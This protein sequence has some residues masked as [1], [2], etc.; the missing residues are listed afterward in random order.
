LKS[1]LWVNVLR[2]NIWTCMSWDLHGETSCLYMTSVGFLVGSWSA[3]KRSAFTCQRRFSGSTTIS[4]PF[5][6]LLRRLGLLN[7]RMWLWPFRILWCMS[8]TRHRGV[9]R[10]GGGSRGSMRRGTSNGSTVYLILL[11]ETLRPLL[12]TQLL[13]LLLQRLLLSNNGPYR[14]LTH[15]ILF[16][17]SKSVDGAMGHPDVFSSYVF[18]G[19]LQGI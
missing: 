17:T 1:I 14:F 3:K 4:W 2:W 10:Q 16:W 8:L 19:V 15:F 18:T 13:S 11:W 7:K 9:G 6:D 5:I 12:S